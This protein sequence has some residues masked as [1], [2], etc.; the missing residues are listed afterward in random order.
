MFR[1]KLP[2]LK[3]NL[4]LTKRAKLRKSTSRSPLKF[5]AQELARELGSTYQKIDVHLGD[6]RLILDLLDGVWKLGNI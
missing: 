2:I 3:K 4:F 6:I 5:S 1:S